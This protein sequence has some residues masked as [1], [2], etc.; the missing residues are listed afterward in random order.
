[1][2]PVTKQQKTRVLCNLLSSYYCVLQP[3]ML[4]QW[5]S[6]KLQLLDY[7]LIYILPIFHNNTQFTLTHF[8]FDE[9]QSHLPSLVQESVYR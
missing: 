1:M 5:A 8:P 7:I 6:I 3:L 4:M 9:I 2:Y